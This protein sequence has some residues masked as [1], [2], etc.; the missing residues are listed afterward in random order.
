MGEMA[1]FAL[2]QVMDWEDMRYDYD[3][4]IIDDEEAYELGLLDED[5]S[6]D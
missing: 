4:G 6:I 3:H 2:D 1:D 5:G